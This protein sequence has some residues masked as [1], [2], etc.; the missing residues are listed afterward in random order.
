MLYSKPVSSTLST[1]EICSICSSRYFYILTHNT[2]Y[3]QQCYSIAAVIA[4]FIYYFQS[5]SQTKFFFLVLAYTL[6][7]ITELQN[8][9]FEKAFDHMHPE[10][11]DKIGRSKDMAAG[12]VLTAGIFR[13]V[14]MAGIALY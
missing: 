13:L 11:H 8:S 9:S 14:V 2:N 7:L 3:R 10:M 12:A 4:I 5:I 6:I 1:I